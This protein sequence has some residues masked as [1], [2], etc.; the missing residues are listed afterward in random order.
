MKNKKGILTIVVAAAIGIFY[1]LDGYMGWGIIGSGALPDI[2]PVQEN[3]Y[4]KA[5]LDAKKANDDGRVDIV[6]TLVAKTDL[7]VSS[8]DVSAGYYKRSSSSSSRSRNRKP[9]FTEYAAFSLIGEDGFEMKKG[10]TREIPGY[11]IM[12]G[13]ISRN[14]VVKVDGYLIHDNDMDSDAY[15][16]DVDKERATNSENN[17]Y[18]FLINQVV[19]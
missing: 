16:A 3:A 18:D 14:L 19:K 13:G 11:F 4:Y 6:V 10:E 1:F 8:M 2:V 9:G 12:D 5:S 15:S 7:Y 17:K